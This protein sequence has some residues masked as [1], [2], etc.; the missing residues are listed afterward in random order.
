[1]VCAFIRPPRPKIYREEALVPWL[2]KRPIMLVP[3]KKKRS[4]TQIL[5]IYL[6][7]KQHTRQVPPHER[8]QLT[9]HKA[10]I[11]IWSHAGG[12]FTSEN[13]KILRKNRKKGRP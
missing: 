13:D 9:A 5:L 3:R 11:P 2:D 7:Q 8:L 1:M 12:V 6:I 4:N 10:R